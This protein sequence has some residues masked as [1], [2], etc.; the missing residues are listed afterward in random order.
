MTEM[1]GTGKSLEEEADK[2]QQRLRKREQLALEERIGV[3]LFRRIHHENW[4]CVLTNSGEIRISET[5][6]PTVRDIEIA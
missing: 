4:F 2:E 6:V 5:S 1:R 3:Y